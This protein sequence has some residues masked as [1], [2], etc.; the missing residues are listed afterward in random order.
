MTSCALVEGSVQ[1]SPERAAEALSAVGRALGE[2]QGM[3]QLVSQGWFVA[4]GPGGGPG[5]ELY[6]FRGGLDGRT[7]ATLNALAPFVEQDAVLVFQDSKGRRWR[8]LMVAGQMSKQTAIELWCD[9][10]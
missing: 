9:V 4:P 6:D 1:I 10:A 5:L 2:P 7:D 8:Y 3:L